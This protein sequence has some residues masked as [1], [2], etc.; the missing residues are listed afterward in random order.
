MYIR[1]DDSCVAE[2]EYVGLVI[3]M[4]QR[5]APNRKLHDPSQRQALGPK[6]FGTGYQLSKREL[7]ESLMERTHECDGTEDIEVLDWKTKHHKILSTHGSMPIKGRADAIF[8]ASY[9]FTPKTQTI[10]CFYS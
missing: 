7:K 8:I 1:E 10:T 4:T 6:Y 5:T 9:Q 2:K 3:G